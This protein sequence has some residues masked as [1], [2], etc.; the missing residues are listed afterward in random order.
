MAE[1]TGLL[2]VALTASL[3][4]VDEIPPTVTVVEI[5]GLFRV[6]LY[7]SGLAEGLTEEETDDDGD[8]EAL[9]ETDALIEELGLKE[10]EGLIL[11]EILEDGDTEA[12]NELDGL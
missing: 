11:A 8:T 12:L 7:G 9:G 4:T 10:A 2:F 1:T 3:F 5:T 6:V